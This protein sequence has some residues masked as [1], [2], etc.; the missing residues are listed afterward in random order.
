LF[1]LASAHMKLAQVGSG[2]VVTVVAGVVVTVVGA[3]AGAA[4]WQGPF[5]AGV[6]GAAVVQGLP[7][8]AVPTAMSKANENIML[9]ALA[10]I[11][12]DSS[13]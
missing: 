10:M 2:V 3:G 9:P 13:D 12:L 8:A 11:P 1:V 6:G 5:G 7:A 4:V